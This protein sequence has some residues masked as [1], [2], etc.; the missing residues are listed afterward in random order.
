MRSGRVDAK[1]DKHNFVFGYTS[2]LFFVL[3][4]ALI[5]AKTNYAT[6][7]Q[8][9]IF[10]RVENL[11]PF[12]NIGAEVV[13]TW[14]CTKM[15]TWKDVKWLTSITSLPVIAK[16]VLTGIGVLAFLV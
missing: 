5:A 8:L 10:Y 16:G 7:K 1:S 13:R 2:K 4:T 15:A 12:M 6:V 14:S 3:P 9:F 11:E